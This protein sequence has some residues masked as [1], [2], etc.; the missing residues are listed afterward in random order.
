MS[1][2]SNKI[3]RMKTMMNYGLKT[4]NKNTQYSSVEYQKVGADGKNYGIVRE[5]AKFYIK[6]SDKTKGA[7]KEDFNYIGGFV[8]RKNNEF[9][10]YAN[11]IK[12]F[13]LKMMSINE[14]QDNNKKILVETWDPEKREMLMVEATETMRNEIERQKE[15][16]LRAMNIS[17]GKSY[18][19]GGEQAK[20][21][22]N[23]IK[24]EGGKLGSQEGNGGDPFTEDPEKEFKQT[25]KNNNKDEFKATVNESEELIYNDNDDY[26]DMSNGTEIGD[27]APFTDC[28]KGGCKKEETVE[29]GTSMHSQGNNQNS[30]SVGIGEVGDDDPFT[31]NVNESIEDLEDVDVDDVELD[32]ADGEEVDDFE[33]FEDEGDVLDSEDDI[34]NDEEDIIDAEDDVETNNVDERISS[35]EAMLEKIAEKLG[36]DAFEDDSLYGDDETEEDDIEDD[37]V[38]YEL[39]GDFDD[40]EDVETSDT[41]EMDDDML[42]E[43]VVIETPNYRK[44]MKENSDYFGKHPAYRKEPMDLPSAKHQEMD[45]YYDMNDES[46]ENESEY[47]VEIGDGQPFTLSPK[48]IENAVVETIMAKLGRKNQ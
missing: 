22:K 3:E 18:E 28:P 40:E 13:E 42:G 1:E 11:A 44:M 36:I 17:E 45:G 9:N 5:G 33:T 21:Q 14:T 32:D 12:Q 2:F 30:P 35:I 31:E 29:E 7:L 38:E 26:M 48:Q 6:V 10:S 27:S 4:E 34:F 47:G 23:N 15:I 46:V 16:M 25:Q 39:E 37:S 43:C 19:I 24:K 41:E 8:N 20:T